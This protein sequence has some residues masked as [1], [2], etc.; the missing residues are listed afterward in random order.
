M[1]VSI[2][3]LD[4]VKAELTITVPA[5]EFVA[6]TKKAYKE[7][8]KY[9]D[10]CFGTIFDINN[11]VDINYENDK[12]TIK[13]FLED[14]KIDYLLNTTR[15]IIDANT[16]ELKGNL[17]TVI[18]NQTAH[19]ETDS[20]RFEVLDRIGGGDAFCAGV[21]HVLNKDYKNIVDALKLGQKC[22]IL[23]HLV[24]GDVLSLSKNEIEE[25]INNNK[26]VIR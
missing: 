13:K 18:N 11:F 17:F 8:L 1:T 16:Q 22:G 4:K 9:V 25:W 7:I 19:Y 5:E 20:E 12:D 14:Y 24:R 3:K 10:V 26:D 21:I 15:K 2:E 23:K 6:A